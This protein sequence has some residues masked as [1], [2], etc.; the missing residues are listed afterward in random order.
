MT[1]VITPTT[2]TVVVVTTSDP[3]VQ[4]VVLTADPSPPASIIVG[5]SGPTGPVGPQGPVGP[6]GAQGVQGVDGAQGVQGN[7]GPP[8]VSTIIIGTKA[9]VA[10]LPP[11]STVNVGDGYIVSADEC[12]YTSDGT[13]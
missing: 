7:Q 1:A 2:P 4:P 13:T 8:G 11:A 9:T 5:P 12:L 6:A 3:D 10:D